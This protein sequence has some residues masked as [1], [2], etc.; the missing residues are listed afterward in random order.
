MTT[1]SVSAAFDRV[2]AGSLVRQEG[3][4]HVAVPARRGMDVVFT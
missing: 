1:A 2:E 4:I 3:V